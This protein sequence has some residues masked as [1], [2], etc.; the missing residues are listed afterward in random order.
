MT[1]WQ[2]S[3]RCTLL[4]RQVGHA[5]LHRHVMRNGSQEL[6]PLRIACITGTGNTAA[7]LEEYAE[8]ISAVI[9]P[10]PERWA[11]QSDLRHAQRIYPVPCC[12]SCT[13]LK[14]CEYACCVEE[15]ERSRVPAGLTPCA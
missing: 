12:H 10:N 5:P 9:A 8:G 1:P 14:Q 7:D 15:W 6:C 4:R 11:S 2:L 3:R 13:C